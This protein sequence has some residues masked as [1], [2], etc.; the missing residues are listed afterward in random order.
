M[1]TYTCCLVILILPELFFFLKKKVRQHFP[2]RSF[3][4]NIQSHKKVYGWEAGKC[5]AMGKW[6]LVKLYFICRKILFDS[7][8]INLIDF[9]YFIYFI[10]G[11][12]LYV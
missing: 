6:E 8:M 11:Y 2:R 1:N 12:N 9:S 4:R 5:E 3:S 7:G 10:S